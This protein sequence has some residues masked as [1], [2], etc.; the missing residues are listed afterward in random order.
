[1]LGS[2]T[3]H[4]PTKLIFGK[5]AMEALAAELAGYGTTVQL[6]YGGGYHALT[7]DEIVAVLRESL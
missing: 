5:D 6:I 7:R 2:F 1:M 3:Y 4:N